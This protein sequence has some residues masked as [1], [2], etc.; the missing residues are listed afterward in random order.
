MLTEELTLAMQLAGRSLS[1][2]CN[3][4]C[5]TPQGCVGSEWG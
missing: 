1:K 3:F 4:M 5:K 2:I